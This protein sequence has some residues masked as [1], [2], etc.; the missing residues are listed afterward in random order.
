M[1]HNKGHDSAGAGSMPQG[2]PG[3]APPPPAVEEPPREAL[4]SLVALYNAG[5]HEDLEAAARPMAAQYP[6][7][8]KALHLLGASRLSRGR[9]TEAAE[10][11]R[12]ALGR[13]P[14]DPEINN[15][16]GV[17]LSGCGRHDEARAC[18]EASLSAGG[19][20]YETLVNA[21]ANANTA[22]DVEGGCK[23]AARALELRP[24]GVEAML[25]LGNALAGAGRSEEAV[26]VYR[27]A[28][29]LSPRAPDLYLNLGQALMS[30]NR[31]GEAAAAFR[32]ALALR[33]DYAPA[34][35]NLGRALHEL[36]DTVGAQRHFRAA[37]DHDP[38]MT[39][40]HSAYLF[41]LSHD[42]G[43]SP[44]DAYAEH[45]RIGELIERPCRGRWRE[46]ENDRD[47]ERDLRIGF[48]SGDLHEHPLAN[49][50]EPIWRAMRAGRNR[51]YVYAN[52]TWRDAVEARL[53][54]LASEWLHV[55]RMSDD[56]LAERIRADRIDILVDLSGH[57]A[58][59]RLPVFARKP[60]PVQ[61]TWLGYP[62]TTGLSTV[63]YR[64]MRGH[65]SGHEAMQ[66]LFRERLV[67]F[68]ARSFEPP[69]ESPAVTPLPALQRG[70]LT[71]GSFNRPSKLGAGVIALWS[72]VLAALPD[73]RLLIA[74]VNEDSLR[75]R[76]QADFT[77]HG[78]AS[79]R[80]DFRPRVAMGEYLALHH[81]VDI[82][83]DTFPYTGG[84]T[85]TF[86]LWMGV[87]VLTLAGAS[88]QQRQSAA[89]LTA[90]AVAD[91]V[92]GSEE[93]F[94]ARVRRAAADLPA[95]G[96]LRAGLREVMEQRMQGSAEQ[97]TDELDATFRTMWRRWCRGQPPEGFVVG[98]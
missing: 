77:A 24:N 64:L 75:D 13:A 97:I 15:L 67:H 51:L 86:A 92:T 46:H 27:R 2:G 18:F 66:A 96:R 7:S 58:R 80:L 12:S 98:A 16:L 33:P 45:I 32:Q 29:S 90:F 21:S 22:G 55:E 68:R 82:A 26:D 69:P 88:L 52:G 89:I 65:E 37:S 62:G 38:G 63:D 9:H 41:S 11:L 78:I 83:L 44:R 91:W 85:T 40:A 61:V 25:N 35:L 19:D 47:P 23:L 53:K 42:P 70:W 56:Q 57:T 60:A 5:R 54:G 8:A 28:I 72:R 34:H 39:E 74:G 10:V 71:F 94:V 31:Y 6:R 95:L 1:E 79:S 81:E 59:N 48:V 76:L 30:R 4:V 43:V 49:L 84:T 3:A 20:N 87:P 50:I 73:A 93:E 36:G 17:A 14:G